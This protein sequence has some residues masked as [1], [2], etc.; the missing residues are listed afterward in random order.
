M[1]RYCLEWSSLRALEP[2]LEEVQAS[3]GRLSAWYNEPTNRALMTSETELSA[4]EV[5]QRYRDLWSS[6]DRPFLFF[7]GD[8]L[9]G[10]CDLRNIEAGQAEYAVMIGP[11]EQQGKGLGTK[12][13]AMVLAFAFGPLGLRRVFV[14]VVPENPASLRMFE[15]LGFRADE[16]PEARRHAD[17]SS[18]LCLSINHAPAIASVRMKVRGCALHNKPCSS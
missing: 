9:V 12:F 2:S 14:S 5:V 7:S 17:A 13:S 11:R 4:E 18:D 15:K 3:A 6:G 10:D 1:D 8:E 16:S